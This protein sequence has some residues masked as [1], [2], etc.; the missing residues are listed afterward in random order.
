MIGAIVVLYNPD[1][2]LLT[3]SLELL[4]SQVDE[5]C[6]IDNSSLDN[7]ERISK[8][9]NVKYIALKENVGIATAQNIGI[10]YFE[11][12]DFDFVFFSDQDSVDESVVI[13]DLIGV[14]HKC[15][16]KGLKIAA[17]SP[18]PVNRAT[19]KPYLSRTNVIKKYLKGELL[20]EYDIIN[21][22]S[23]ISS[24]SLVKISTYK[25]V[26]YLESELFIDGVDSEWCW[27]ADSMCGLKSYIVSDLTFS[28]FQGI[29]E[30]AKYK[31][32]SPFRSY[33]Q[34]RN[35]IVLFRRK[36][37]PF[38]WKI[39]NLVKFS[40]KLFYYPL[41]VNPRVKYLNSIIRGI[42]DG[43]KNKMGK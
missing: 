37:V 20:E 33:Y 13:A 26:G 8:S 19:N 7:S 21:V 24:F 10:K 14:Y 17:I 28:H 4:M 36:Y 35:F 27:R 22:K 1:F 3:R 29:D 39:V 38:S 31:K 15:E 32:S 25:S 16:S 6:L 2:N 40:I 12:K 34:Y 23:V 42:K 11:Q 5:V 43:L 30:R 9:Q 41:C 18:M